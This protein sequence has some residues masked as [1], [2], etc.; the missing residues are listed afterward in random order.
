MVLESVPQVVA[1]VILADLF[2][3]S[4]DFER[5]PSFKEGTRTRKEPVLRFLWF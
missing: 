4:W 5:A 3:I 2:C 1:Y